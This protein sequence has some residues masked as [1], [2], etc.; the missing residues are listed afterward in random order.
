MA[1]LL[2]LH[3]ASILLASCATNE[4]VEDFGDNIMQSGI[5]GTDECVS[6]G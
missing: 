5:L 1:A 6:S 2:D 3:V 4:R